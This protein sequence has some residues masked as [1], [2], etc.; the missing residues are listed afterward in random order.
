VFDSADLDRA[1]SGVMTGIFSASGQSCAAGSRILV[2]DSI[3]DDFFEALATR[4]RAL[5]LGDPLDP[6]TQISPVAS[7]AQLAK[8]LGYIELAQKEGATTLVGGGRA[9]APGLTEGFFVE[10]TI[11]TGVTN[12]ATVSRE[13]IFGPVG[14][15]IRFK[16]EDDAVRIANDTQYGLAAGIWTENVA[17]AHRMTKRVHAG[18][19]WVNNSRLG[20]LVIP[21]GGYGATGGSREMGIEALRDYQGTKAI[22]IDLGSPLPF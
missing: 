20:E 10:P 21:W 19:V 2:Q 5:R 14:A 6:A 11:F 3:G 22:Y 13:E 12:D 18:L 9:S 17:L 7:R 1:I 4:I 8:V 16:D 15:V